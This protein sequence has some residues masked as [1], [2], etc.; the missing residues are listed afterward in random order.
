MKYF[1]YLFF[2]LSL[3]YSC[4]K[5]P[6]PPLQPPGVKSDIPN[7]FPTEKDY[8]KEILISGEYTLTKN[9]KSFQFNSEGQRLVLP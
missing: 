6:S 5:P 7:L 8:P 3:S 1:V 2:I 4:F 9:N